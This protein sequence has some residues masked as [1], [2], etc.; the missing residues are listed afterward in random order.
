M[1]KIIVRLIDD[2][3]VIVNDEYVWID[4]VFNDLNDNNDFIRI[5]DN[6]FSKGEIKH[7]HV[8][9]VEEE[10]EKDVTTCEQA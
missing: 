5:E 6:L 8:E 7:I 1:K 10:V 3:N 9:D 4:R 2:T